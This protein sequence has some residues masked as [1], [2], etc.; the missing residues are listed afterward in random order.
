LASARPRLAVAPLDGDKD[1]DVAE[2]VA[3]A[4]ADHGKTTRPD[5]VSREIE[6]LEIASLNA[7]TVKKL[8]IKLEADV[9]IYGSVDKQGGKKHLELMLTGHGKSK[10]KL[11]IDFKTTKALKKEL[12]DKLGKQID[13]AAASADDEGDDDDDDRASKRKQREAEA[14]KERKQREDDAKKQREAEAEK[15]RKRKKHGDDE[16]R[17]DNERKH[18][19]KKR[20]ASRDEDTDD[21][22]TSVHRKKKRRHRGD[23]DGDEDEDG[24]A[25][26]R[27]RHPI[28]QAAAWADIGAAVARRTLTYDAAGNQQPPPVGTAAPAGEIEGEVY[29]ASFSTLKGPAAGIGVAGAYDRSLGLGIAVP[30][31]AVVAPI[32][33][34][35]YWIGAR[36]RFTFGGSSVAVG[37]SYWRRY[38]MADRSKLTMPTDL[39]MPDVDYTALAPDVT[40]RFAATPKLGVFAALQL[41]LMLSS[42]PI[43]SSTSYGP[44]T[45][46]AFDLRTGVQI[47]LGA[48]YALQIALGFDQIGLKFNAKQGSQAALR[49]VSAATDRSLGLAATLGVMY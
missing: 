1:G 38:Y 3:D 32:K 47:G 2:L 15:E 20:T 12:E 7:K 14:E 28:T 45:I 11:E 19:S 22:D 40:A 27:P 30:G 23:D 24:E 29:P 42:G 8:R 9:V 25:A 4:A 39:D 41:P 48:H 21:D 13:V 34:G 6:K 10:A 33:S 46:I 26:P 16:E 35:F 5:Q 44:S 17:D 37:A 49:E 36:Y 18:T 43:Q 31:T